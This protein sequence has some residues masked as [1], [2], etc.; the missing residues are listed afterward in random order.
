MILLKNFKIQTT[1]IMYDAFTGS[2]SISSAAWTILN[3]LNPAVDIKAAVS[4]VTNFIDNIRLALG[5]N[6]SV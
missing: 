4:L 6:V 1:N 2:I 3:I 5:G